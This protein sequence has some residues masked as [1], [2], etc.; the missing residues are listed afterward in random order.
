VVSRPKITR[1]AG[2]Q[3]QELY[4]IGLELERELVS[5][6]PDGKQLDKAVRLVGS[7]PTRP[8]ITHCQL[9][10]ESEWINDK[11]TFVGVG[12]LRVPCG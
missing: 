1:W 2:E 3:D 11:G 12:R 4:R 6:A 9:P 7:C 8:L 10:G 5:N